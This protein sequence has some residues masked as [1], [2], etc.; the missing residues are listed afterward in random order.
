M[1]SCEYHYVLLPKTNGS[2]IFEIS[3]YSASLTILPTIYAGP[4]SQAMPVSGLGGCPL[5]KEALTFIVAKQIDYSGLAHLTPTR[6]SSDVFLDVLLHLNLRSVF[7]QG[8][9]GME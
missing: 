2:T 8:G 7:E 6:K 4:A 9:P 1:A 5:A 3:G